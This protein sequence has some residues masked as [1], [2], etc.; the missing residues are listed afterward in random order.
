MAPRCAQDSIDLFEKLFA[1]LGK[2]RI[3]S[4]VGRYYAMDRDNRWDRVQEA[5]E[6]LTEGKSAFANY[7]SATD[8]L[9]A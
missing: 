7:A 8:A 5:Y 6:L 3:A 1:K 4:L 2:G 9:A